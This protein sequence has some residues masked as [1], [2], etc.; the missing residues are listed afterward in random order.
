[1]WWR[2]RLPALPLE[3]RL[4]LAA[5]LGLHDMP[6]RVVEELHEAPGLHAGDHPVEA[7][8]VEVDD[9]QHIAEALERRVGDGLPHVALVELGIAHQR[10]EP[11]GGPGPEVGV[12]IAASGRREQRS[13]SAEANRAGREVEDVRVLRAAR[14]GLE[15]AQLAQ[16]GEVGGIELAGQV[17]DGMED[18]GRMRLHRHLVVAVQVGEP[19]RSH[20]ADH[21]G[22][23]GLVAADLDLAGRPVVVGHIHDAHGQPEQAL[24]DL[25]QRGQRGLAERVV[26]RAHRRPA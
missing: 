26:A 10:D 18:R 3:G 24:L 14:V 1:M 21:R 17:L 4:Q 2:R 16:P 13:D 7:L 20:D 12:D 9:P 19:Q 22:R 5:V 11:G 6:A 23:A 15:A 8:A 25:L